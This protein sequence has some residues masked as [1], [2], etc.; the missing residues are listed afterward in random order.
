MKNKSPGELCPRFWVSTVA[1]LLLICISVGLVAR[2]V[3]LDSEARAAYVQSKEALDQIVEESDALWA[4]GTQLYAKSGKNVRSQ[5]AYRE[6]DSVLGAQIPDMVGGA[7]FV[8]DPR[9]S[10]RGTLLFATESNEALSIE[11]A[12]HAADLKVGIDNLQKIVDADKH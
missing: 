4:E 3:V 12:N 1:V 11:F 2:E 5:A 6:L 9:D 10:T 7:G 8:N